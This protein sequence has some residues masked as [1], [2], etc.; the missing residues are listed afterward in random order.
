MITEDR[1]DKIYEAFDSAFDVIHEA[2]NQIEVDHKLTTEEGDELR[3]KL[4]EE[5]RFWRR[6]KVSEA[7]AL[8]TDDTAL[9]EYR[10]KVLLEAA[11]RLREVDSYMRLFGTTP[12]K[13]LRRM[14]EEE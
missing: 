9:R 8:P 10:R 13:L 1:W 11:E 6:A 3:L 7:L 2:V 5:F 4:T 12:E 14:A